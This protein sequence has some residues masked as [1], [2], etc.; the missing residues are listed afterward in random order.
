MDSIAVHPIVT[1][2]IWLGVSALL[3]LFA[4]IARFY[5]RLS[6]ERTYYFL[7]FLAIT[8]LAGASMRQITRDQLAGDALADLLTAAGGALV[9]ALCLHIYRLMIRGR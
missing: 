9:G 1:L 7:F 4:L 5:E 3:V 8:L 2:Y 6:G